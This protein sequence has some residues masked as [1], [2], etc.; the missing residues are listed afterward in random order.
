MQFPHRI[1]LESV[2]ASLRSDCHRLLRIPKAC[3]IETRTPAALWL[4]ILCSKQMS[5]HPQCRQGS[6]N[7]LPIRLN[8]LHYG[9]FWIEV[10]SEQWSPTGNAESA[11]T[12][13]PPGAKNRSVRLVWEDRAIVED[14]SIMARSRAGTR[15]EQTWSVFRLWSQT[16]RVENPYLDLYDKKTKNSSLGE[17]GSRG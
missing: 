11:T 4:K 14:A 6:S 13:C 17:I 8:E 12:Y 7:S 10:Y 15:T 3:S 16:A 1:D 2:V 5:V 9:A